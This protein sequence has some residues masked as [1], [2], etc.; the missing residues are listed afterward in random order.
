MQRELMSPAAARRAGSTEAREGWQFLLRSIGD[1]WAVL[2]ASFVAAF[3][4]TGVVVAV[5]LLLG[6]AVNA[7]IIGHDVRE[8]AALTALI[9]LLA[10]VQASASGLRR[11]TNG[12]AS[13]RLETELRQRFFS[14]LLRLEIAY[15]DQ[16]NRGQLLSR[17]TSDLFQ[18]Q[19]FV[20]SSPAWTANVIVVLAVAGVLLAINPRLGAVTLAGLPFVA[21]GSKIFSTN[22]RPPLT[23]LQSERGMLAGVVEEAVSGVRAVKGFG[24]EA[25]LERRLG[26]QADRVRDRALD[27]V[28]LRTRFI[29]VVS[30]VPL[31]ELAALNWLGAVFVLHH[32][33]SIGTLLAFNAYVGLIAPP[34]QSIG[35]YI[36]LGQRA[37]VSSRRLHTVMRRT[38]AIAEPKNPEPLPGGSGALTFEQVCFTYPAA[39]APVFHGLE[40]LV[41]GGEVVALVG[42][43]GSGKSTLLALVS[44][45]YDPAAGAVRLD[46]ADLRRV[47]LKG[48]R[49]ATAVVFEENFLFDDTIRANICLGRSD[50]TNEQLAR[51]LALAR[52]EGFVA[53]LPDGLDTVVGERGLALSGG[54]RQRLALARALVNEPRVLMLDDA[55]SA[56]DAANERAIVAGLSRE[57]RGKTTI[58]VSHRPATI[59]AADRVVLLDGGTV[60]ATGRHED[61]VEGCPRYLEVLGA[62]DYEDT[63][64]EDTDGE[65]RAGEDRAGEDRAC[66]DAGG[67]DRAGEDAAGNRASGADAAG[68]S[69]S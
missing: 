35:G 31:L 50:V 7:G 36:V 64:G 17:L 34:V 54:Q 62:A 25:L 47:S 61:L 3:V 63:D 38:P 40:L 46:G 68:R 41:E 58:I 33:L 55:T 32:E 42:P 15:H 22:I 18:I 14:K 11:W 56:I 4:W 65:D 26:V 10:L 8:F 27:V 53:D 51:A 21:L 23:D 60:V 69:A 48:L 24:S 19:Q 6:A 44:R 2:G 67:E 52:A 59:A 45:L 39:T 29:P 16:V 49:A 13:R 37:I 66:E 1:N 43:T 20:S 28:A 12:L 9:A 57:R 30:T 5:P